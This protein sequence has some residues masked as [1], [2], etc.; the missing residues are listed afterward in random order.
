MTGPALR[1]AGE[2]LAAPLPPLLAEAEHLAATVILGDHGRRRAGMGDEFWQYR[3]ASPGDSTRRIDWRRSAREENTQFVRETEWQAAQTVDIWVDG[4]QSMA[5]ASASTLVQKGQ[6]ARVLAMAV[7][8]LLI[9]GGE[10]VG[11]SAAQ[12]P[13]RS[14]D[15]QITRLA[16]ALVA[17]DVPQ[18]Y[19]A[20]DTRAVPSRARA[21]FISDFLGDIAPVRKAITAAADRGIRGAILQV[22]DPT[23]ESFP[24]DGRTL[25]QSMS[26]AME[27]ETQKAGSLKDRY[28]ARLAARKAELAD[29][30][31]TTG[32]QFSTHHTD[33]SAM[34]ALLW[35]YQALERRV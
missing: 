5:Y 6:R 24:F 9:R 23:E 17:H 7:A 33:S 21:I 27:F 35:A 34:T 3:H 25:F 2:S 30:A 20:P 29:L 4:A 14:G 12:I 11:L 18:D 13:A 26:G 22:L 8:I 10:R 28:Q 15:L 32:W 19:G 16:D 31:L 1:E